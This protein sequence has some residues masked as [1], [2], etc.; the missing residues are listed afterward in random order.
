MV[1]CN[2]HCI[3]YCSLQCIK[4]RYAYY[5]FKIVWYCIDACNCMQ[6][7]LSLAML[8]RIWNSS[9]YNSFSHK[10]PQHIGA[11]ADRASHGL[12]WTHYSYV[13]R[14]GTGT[15]NGRKRFAAL[16]QVTF[17]PCTPHIAVPG[18]TTASSKGSRPRS[19]HCSQV[20]QLMAHNCS[21]CKVPVVITHSAPLTED[22]NLNTSYI[23]SVPSHQTDIAF[24]C[25]LIL[26][27]ICKDGCTVIRVHTYYRAE[28]F[29]NYC[30][31]HCLILN[32]CQKHLTDTTATQGLFIVICVAPWSMRI[33]STD[34][35]LAF[36]A[37][38]NSL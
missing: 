17:S 8:G 28:I 32:I 35:P 1:N 26:C 31:C 15:S 24:F 37:L 6:W 23:W 27:N 4:Y 3:D 18:W 7:Y 11:E 16:S 9:V 19:S 2:L 20:P 13:L 22:K 33:L 38:Q 36:N 5:S 12:T 34:Y 25:C 14:M 10:R 29:A 30:M 21:I